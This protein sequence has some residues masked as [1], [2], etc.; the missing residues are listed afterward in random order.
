MQ[1]NNI[2]STATR[3]ARSTLNAMS[4]LRLIVLEKVPGYGSGEGHL[5]SI[6]HATANMPAIRMSQPS[7]P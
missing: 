4:N 3:V 1:A 5:L 2:A 6:H 7:T